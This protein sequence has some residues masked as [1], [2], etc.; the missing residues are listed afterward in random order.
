M[1]FSRVPPPMRVQFTI[2]FLFQIL[3]LHKNTLCSPPDDPIK[4]VSGLVDCTVTNSYGAFSDQA[5]C[6]ASAAVYP[7]SENEL[8]NIVASATKANRK[9]KVATRYGHSRPNLVCLKGNDGLLISTKSLNKVISVNKTSMTMTFQSGILL[10]D[11]IDEAAKVGMALPY[12]PY[13]WGVTLG[14]MLGTGAHGSSIWGKGGAVHE[15]VVGL[16]IITPAEAR[17]G[18]A[19]VR[20]LDEGHPDLDAAKVHLGVLGVISQV[21]LD[22]MFP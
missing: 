20:V 21:S 4:C 22:F 13:W 15:N 17:E 5:T 9:M 19:K 10:R 18:Y 16:R 1:L 2:L 14:G 12:G 6:R 7:T 8:I 3:F 11:L